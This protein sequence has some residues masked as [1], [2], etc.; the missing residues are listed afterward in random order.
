MADADLNAGGDGSAAGADDAG[1]AQATQGG[2]PAGGAA[3]GGAGGAPAGGRGDAG[4]GSG[5]GEG[6]GK[7]GDAGQGDGKGAP[8]GDWPGDWRERY[9]KGD[10]KKL[11]RLSRYASPEAALDAMIAAQNRISSGELKST[12]PKNA[13]EEQIAAWR[14]ENGVPEAPEKYDLKFEDGLV[15]G[16]DDKPI[17][18]A[19]LK[20]AHGANLT[21]DQA[22]AAVRW[23]FKHQD[24][25]IAAAHEE[26]KRVE[27][28]AEDALRVEWGQEFR[29]NW[30]AISGLVD[31][32]VPADNET[33]KKRIVAGAK[34]DPGFARFLAQVAIERNPAGTI[35]G[36]P[37]GGNLG[38]SI[39][40]SIKEIEEKMRADRPAYNRDE[41]MQ[42]RYRKLLEA[43][44][45]NKA[46]A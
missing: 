6:A 21:N 2:A 42:E 24:E 9:A 19:F 29:G 30:N 10:D 40:D 12:L 46:K 1:N 36:M 7:T 18:D 17:V 43:R 22:K 20:D 8:A 28:E 25:Q 34:Q 44:E 16:D 15:I 26:R 31:G 14:A 3:A 4:T 41:K 27:Q 45:R 39:D 5:A 23:Y 38:Q 35:I 11:S 33:L 37:D 32:L 13:T